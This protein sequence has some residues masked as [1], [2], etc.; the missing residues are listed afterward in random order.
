MVNVA[1]HAQT[2][3]SP[4]SNGPV[5]V[6]NA[7]TR[8][9]DL[10]EP[11]VVWVRVDWKAW[12]VTDW[13]AFPEAW[14]TGCSGLIVNPGGYIVTAG[15]CVDDGWEGA[16]GSALEYAVDE[17]I[18]NGDV[19][20]SKRE[21]LI[22]D[23]KSGAIRWKVEGHDQDS[24]PDPVVHVQVGGGPV[25]WRDN[26]EQAQGTSARV[27]D[28]RPWSKGDVALLKVEDD[29]LPV[30]PLAPKSDIQVG[31]ELL[32]IGYPL[33]LASAREGDT[34]ALTARNG[35]VN[36]VDSTAMNGPGNLFYETSAA[37]TAGMSG[38]PSVDLQGRVI[39]LN[40]TVTE[41]RISYVVPS[42]V[43]LEMLNRNGIK[44]E[45]GRLDQLYREGLDNYYQGYHTDAIKDFDQVLA[46]VPNHHQ[47]IDKKARAANLRQQFGDQP[48]PAATVKSKGF[49]WALPAIVAS[50]ALA[51]VSALVGGWLWRRKRARALRA[52]AGGVPSPAV[53][54]PAL[55][56]PAA[57]AA[58]D[59]DNM[60]N[61]PPSGN[62]HRS[63][64]WTHDESTTALSE[65]TSSAME[66][67]P[68]PSTGTTVVKDT[69]PKCGRQF[70]PDAAYAYCPD[71][72]TRLG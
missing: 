12:V 41:D 47:A 69:C 49:D 66:G 72:G 2:A 38:G 42:S 45:Q 35:Q 6:V 51:A 70:D 31:Q 23:V 40:S 59:T 1:A 55:P 53:P 16:Q 60:A 36:S 19:S 50:L 57:S 44:N 13:K 33:A 58:E 39:G 29:N 14:T 27:L 28:F 32:S 21:Q 71:C 25:K 34:V 52:P 9:A 10:V 3:P 63:Q 15:H 22:D 43:V 11:G 8:A 65:S 56:A 20:A 7:Q 62:G 46:M 48:K 61:V 67:V 68:S 30:V 54:P 64:T 37:L 18:D 24:R 17:M 4:G 5:P 26:V